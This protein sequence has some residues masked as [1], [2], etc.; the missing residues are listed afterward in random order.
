MYYNPDF[1]ETI[2]TETRLLDIF[3]FIYICLLFYRSFSD[4][5]LDFR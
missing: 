5:Y 1:N 4:M 3:V 2:A